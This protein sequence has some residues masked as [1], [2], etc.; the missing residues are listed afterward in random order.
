[1]L[2]VSALVAVA[3]LESFT[4]TVKLLVPAVVGVPEIAPAG[5][6]ASPAGRLPL[7]TV[8]WLPPLPPLAASVWEYGVPA[9]PSGSDAVVTLRPGGAIVM[10]SAW[11][12]VALLESFTWTVKLL[13]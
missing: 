3:L 11:V 10:V 7:A 5:E 4:C 12:A 8:H 9:T 1:M 2:M 6:S 13:G